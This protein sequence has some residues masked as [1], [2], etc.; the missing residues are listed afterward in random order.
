MSRV[1]GSF[2]IRFQEQPFFKIESASPWSARKAIGICKL[3]SADLMMMQIPPSFG[4]PSFL[5]SFPLF[6][7]YPDGVGSKFP[8]RIQSTLRPHTIMEQRGG[9]KLTTC[10]WGWALDCSSCQWKNELGSWMLKVRFISP[11]FNLVCRLR[12]WQRGKDSSLSVSPSLSPCAPSL[13]EDAGILQLQLCIMC[14]YQ[15]GS[16]GCSGTLLLAKFKLSWSIRV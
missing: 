8:K 4:L 2:Q 12:A 7:A 1:F 11:L 3:G 9:M 6:N 5:P 14:P 13:S 15:S 10:N 16:A